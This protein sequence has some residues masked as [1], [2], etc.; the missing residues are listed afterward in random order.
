MDDIRVT[1]TN[2][3]L[4]VVSP[5]HPE[6]PGR[7][8][9]LMVVGIRT[10]ACGRSR[11]A[12]APTWSKSSTSCSATANPQPTPS[13]SD[14]PSATRLCTRNA[15]V[16]VPPVGSWRAPVGETAQRSSARAL[17]PMKGSVGSGSRQNWR[18][19]VA[20]HS[21]LHIE[22]ELPRSAAEHPV[23]N[24]A[25]WSCA[26][27][28]DEAATRPDPAELLARRGAGENRLREIDDLLG[29]GEPPCG[30]SAALPP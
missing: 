26:K 28:V 21:E 12:T 2:E 10:V 23:S 24:P 14:S 4:I 22:P 27:I 13:S 11:H 7:A 17:P 18:T 8:R 1:E 3:Q 25:P 16:C 5:Y 6:F 15:T 30:G 29:A 19:V 20:A 9:N